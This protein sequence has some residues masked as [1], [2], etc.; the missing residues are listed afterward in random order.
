MERTVDALVGIY[1]EAIADRSE[2]TADDKLRAASRYLRRVATITKGSYDTD[3]ELAIVR[4]EVATQRARAERAEAI[5]ASA[6]A[7][8]SAGT[9]ET[10]RVREQIAAMRDTKVWRL[11]QTYFRWTKGAFRRP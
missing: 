10:T 4:P 9:A 6:T 11:R 8:A 3:H 2:A 1:E 5:A 7:E